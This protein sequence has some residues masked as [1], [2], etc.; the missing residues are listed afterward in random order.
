MK[1]SCATYKMLST[2][3]RIASEASFPY[4][5]ITVH[6]NESANTLYINGTL[7]EK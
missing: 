6:D 4:T 5:T 7:G 2:F 3:Q 1:M